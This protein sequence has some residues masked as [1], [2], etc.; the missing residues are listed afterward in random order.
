MRNN[1]EEILANLLLEWDEKWQLGRDV[2][3]AELCREHPHLTQKLA[4]RIRALKTSSWLDKPWEPTQEG[5]VAPSAQPVQP[6]VLA[7][8]YRLD[9]L[10]AEGGFAQVWRAFDLELQRT[11]AVKF[12]KADKLNAT[13]A[14][15]AEARRV[16][17]LKHPGIVPVHDVRREGGICFIVSEFVEG[18]SLEDHIAKRPDSARAIEWVAQIAEALDYAHLAGIIHRDIKP[19]N[20]LIDHHGRALLADFGIAR[21][22]SNS[23]TLA[24]S[25][26]T[27]P[28]MPREQLEGKEH[29]AR[30]DIY[31]LGVVLHELLT[32]RL[33]YSSDDPI[34]LRKEIVE[35]A[36]PGHLP[37]MA[38]A[39]VARALAPDP[40]ARYQTAARLAADLRRCRTD[41]P[42]RWP[43]VTAVASL[44]I[45]LGIAGFALWPKN[46]PAMP[47]DAWFKATSRLAAE[48][49]ARAVADMLRQLNPG[50]DG[51]VNPTIENGVVT[52]LEFLTDH[53]AAIAPVRALK[54]LKSLS[55]KGTFGTR[56]NGILADLSP[57]RGMSL[58]RLEV[59]ENSQITDLD[60]LRSAP[61]EHLS[62]PRT[63]LTDLK[64]VSAMPL[65]VL[66]CG[67]TEIADLS[68][69]KGMPIRKLFCNNTKVTDL[70]PLSG[71]PMEDLRC[72]DTAIRSLEPLRGSP[73][74]GLD[75]QGTKIDDLGFLQGNKTIAIL[76]INGTMV[77]DLSP[78]RES[79]GLKRIWC[80]F[81]AGRDAALLR[82][83]KSL[84]RINDRPAAE[85]LKRQGN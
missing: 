33:P 85:F 34:V 82:E 48:S 64:A 83:L 62:C 22:P 56:S 32:G 20:I 11:V 46:D 57:L 19:A 78:L 7:G 66:I 41:R 51:A 2:P 30:S 13:D 4:R 16:A 25:F 75:C 40:A 59:D 72:H 1:D 35:G 50:F 54:G 76:K 18:G 84:E 47:N 69:L 23:M 65:Q 36:R 8:R 49:Q 71:S 67:S 77:R 80:D 63:G 5:G 53:V 81:V 12:P 58:T 24:S 43:A 37:A 10:C 27:L 6:R 28:Y 55:C 17:R 70:S 15:M 61:I 3:A 44:P 21:S 45:I 79:A 26:G 68:P 73:L 39:I 14:F 42:T 9:T 38:R 52:G 60:P 31:S 74:V 29:D